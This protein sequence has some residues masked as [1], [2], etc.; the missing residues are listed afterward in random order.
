MH[1]MRYMETKFHYSLFFTPTLA[2]QS[3]LQVTIDETS[4]EWLI[5]GVSK[6][7]IPV[8]RPKLAL[9][10][11]LLTF[12]FSLLLHPTK[13]SAAGPSV[14]IAGYESDN[15]V[16]FDLTTGKWKEIARLPAGSQPRGVTV[17][18]TGEIYVGLH[19]GKKNLV[20]LELG[21]KST[22]VSDITGPI[23]RFGPGILAA[24]KG[25]IWAAG[26]TDR[27]IYQINPSTGEVTGPPQYQ[28]CCNLVGLVADGDVLYTAEYFQRSILRYDLS[29]EPVTSSR[30]ITKDPHLNRP[31][32]L[33]IGHN[34]NLFVAN[35]LEP[36]VIEFN[37]KTGEYIRTFANLGLGGKEGIHGLVYVPETKHYYI[38]SG[39][40]LYETDL[41]GN[42]TASY[43]S[44]AL[45][46][47]YG[48]ALIPAGMQLATIKTKKTN[49]TAVAN[50]TSKPVAPAALA[51]PGESAAS[52]S[53]HAQV[54]LLKLNPQTPGRLSISGAP[55]KRYRVM[56]T[57]D[58]TTWD[59][60]AEIDN[61]TG[62]VEFH[63]SEVNRF[64][65]RFYRLEE[66]NPDR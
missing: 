53:T 48:I 32:G 21:N 42:L 39:S 64:E 52:E 46:K 57:T 2:L 8:N 6:V 56:A 3:N 43:N 35:G 12:V 31:V 36:T 13:V 62:D 14:I 17:S 15:I 34:G 60:I 59:A 7:Y 30:F 66:V 9:A 16:Q 28:N 61:P 10:G 24:G 19:G 1:Y 22:H 63:D 11:L 27:V 37:I 25:K 29:K 5:E 4:V 38:A 51:A 50:T 45:K 58:F 49:P 18:A 54:T 40:S 55:G 20:K 65:M 47:A 23:G 41:E 33:V 26:D 44:P